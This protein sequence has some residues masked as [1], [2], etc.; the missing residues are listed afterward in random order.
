METDEKSLISDISVD[1]VMDEDPLLTSTPR[2]DSVDTNGESDVENMALV[3]PEG[4][5]VVPDTRRYTHMQKTGD[6]AMEKHVF[7]RLE[8]LGLLEN[9]KHLEKQ[10]AER[11]E[12]EIVRG[13]HIVGA[14]SR[15]RRQREGQRQSSRSE[16]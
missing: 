12:K 3:I 14:I 8:S 11:L 5:W 7:D 9:K 6:V 4:N 10:L 2:R 13:D 15:S 16:K 1:T